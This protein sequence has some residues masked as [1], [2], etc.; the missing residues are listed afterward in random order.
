MNSRG[1]NLCCLVEAKS[2]YGCDLCL[3]RS[4]FELYKAEHV[5]INTLFLSHRYCFMCVNMGEIHRPSLP[6][7]LS[8][9]IAEIVFVLCMTE[10]KQC[11]S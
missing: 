7:I 11:I 6:S 2:V 1:A 10:K 5:E 3:E 8:S 4:F 9:V